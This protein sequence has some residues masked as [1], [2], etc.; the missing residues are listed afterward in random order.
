MCQNAPV[1]SCPVSWTLCAHCAVLLTW[2]APR[3]NCFLMLGF[4][5]LAHLCSLCY[6]ITAYAGCNPVC[7]ITDAIIYIT[8][9]KAYKSATAKG[10]CAE[11]HC[12]I[13]T[14][15]CSLLSDHT[16]YSRCAYAIENNWT[17]LWPAL[18]WI[19]FCLEMKKKWRGWTQ[20]WQNK[21]ISAFSPGLTASNSLKLECEC[22]ICDISNNFLKWYFNLGFWFTHPLQ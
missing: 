17:V 10:A 6:F 4:I 2:V 12:C 15:S 14:R 20:Y 22:T 11:P 18:L 16:V 1:N 13:F 3:C 5:V 8:E 9:D 21:D 7:H 19:L